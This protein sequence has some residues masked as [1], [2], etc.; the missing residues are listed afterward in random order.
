MSWEKKFV[1]LWKSIIFRNNLIKTKESWQGISCKATNNPG[2]N[3]V[4]VKGGGWEGGLGGVFFLT[5]W[6]ISKGIRYSN[7]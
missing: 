6:L 5:P 1:F 2:E 3:L 7:K 4:G